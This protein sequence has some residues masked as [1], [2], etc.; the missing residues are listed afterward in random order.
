MRAKMGEVGRTS[1]FSFCP[2]GPV[3]S[4]KGVKNEMLGR[5]AQM[6]EKE[7]ERAKKGENRGRF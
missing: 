3:W 4:Q 5:L 7:S 1:E 2:R 6:S